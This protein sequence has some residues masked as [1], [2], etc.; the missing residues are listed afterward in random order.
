MWT[1]RRI[2]RCNQLVETYELKV[3]VENLYFLKFNIDIRVFESVADIRVG[4]VVKCPGV[5]PRGIRLVP[6]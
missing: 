4:Y 1:D 3:T 6:L 2:E 5:K